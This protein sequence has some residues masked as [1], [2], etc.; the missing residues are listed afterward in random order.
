MRGRPETSALYVQI[1]RAEAEKLDR[2]AFEV[3]AP[4]RELVAALVSRYVDPSTP[5]GLDRLRELAPSATPRRE[6]PRPDPR[7]PRREPTIA[8]SRASEW[9]AGMQRAI[10]EF[11]RSH[12][13]PTPVVRATLHDGEPLFLEG[14]SA[15]PGEDFV[16][17]TA[18]APGEETARVVVVR[19]DA[20]VRVDMLRTAPGAASEAFVYRP[21]PAGVG[22]ARGG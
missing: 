17:L 9:V 14:M 19:L 18:H 13:C 20:V 7:A 4:K 3:R 5:E 10:R 21:R 12:D 16:S 6:I 8:I 11:A 22:F 2:A 1:P 15:G